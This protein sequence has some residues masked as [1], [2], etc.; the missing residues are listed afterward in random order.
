MT[1]RPSRPPAPKPTDDDAWLA[2][3]QDAQRTRAD[4]AVS[5]GIDG[6]ALVGSRSVEDADHVVTVTDRRAARCSCWLFKRKKP[7]P[8]RA[9]V[10]IRLWEEDFGADL[11]TVGARA[12]LLTLSN[13]YLELPKQTH[14]RWWLGSPDG[15][16]TRLTA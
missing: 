14:D 15:P 16:E 7:C 11:S 10:A 6:V 1:A 13:A 3:I 12:L 4:L 5:V 2:A 8:H 9:Y